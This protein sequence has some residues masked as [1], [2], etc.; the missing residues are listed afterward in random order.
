MDQWKP[1]SSV[2]TWVLYFQRKIIVVWEIKDFCHSI[3][4]NK[5]I[6]I[7]PVLRP[8][9]NAGLGGINVISTHQYQDILLH[10][11]E[12]LTFCIFFLFCRQL[13]SSSSSSPSCLP[14]F[15]DV[16]TNSVRKNWWNYPLISFHFVSKIIP[17]YPFHLPC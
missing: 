4:Y 6:G 5:L 7:Y 3:K 14:R 12:K 1:G 2:R 17:T 9:E 13:F 11:K 10:Q 8:L 15:L 16:V